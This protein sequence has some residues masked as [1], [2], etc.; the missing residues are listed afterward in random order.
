LYSAVGGKPPGRGQAVGDHGQQRVP[1]HRWWVPSSG[2]ASN[3]QVAARTP[4]PRRHVLSN[5]GTARWG[6][7][8][9]ADLERSRRRRRGNALEGAG[10]EQSGPEDREQRASRRSWTRAIGTGGPRE[11]ASRRSWTRAIGTSGPRGAPAPRRSWTRAIG[12]GGPR[13]ATRS[14]A[15]RSRAI[16]AGTTRSSPAGP[17]DVEQSTTAGQQDRRGPSISCMEGPSSFPGS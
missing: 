8:V 14:T 5:Q 3:R 2:R 17:V 11:A 9:Q 12:T 10:L 13:G 7:L 15:C 4:V 16:G 1:E 6:S